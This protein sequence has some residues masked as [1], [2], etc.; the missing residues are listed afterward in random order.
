MKWS[1]LALLATSCIASHV[2]LD[3]KSSCIGIQYDFGD[4]GGA[5]DTRADAVKAAYVDAWNDYADHAFGFD[6]YNPLTKTGTTG[7]GGWGLI[8]IDGFDTAVIMGLKDI[9]D[10]QL[11]H[12]ASQ[13]F[14]VSTDP[15]I[16]EFD[17]IIRLIGGLL[18][19]YDLIT[20]QLVPFAGDYNQTQVAKLLD[21]AKTLADF[22][23]P[24]FSSPTG[25]PYFWINT[26]TR[27]PSEGFF[28][29]TAT[30]G[31]VIL[32][33]HRLSDLTGDETY[34]NQADRAEAWLLNPQPAPV[35]P[36][37]VG[38]QVNIDSGQFENENAGW[39]SGVDSFFE[40]LIKSVVYDDTQQYAGEYQSFWTTAVES[41]QQH[42]AVHP[43]NHSELTFINILNNTGYPTDE[44]D[45][46]S[47]FAGGNW[48]LGEHTC[49]ALYNSTASGLNPLA[50]GWYDAETNLAYEAKYNNDS[51]EAAVARANADEWGYFIRYDDYGA[52]YT[53]YPE[54]IESMF[55]AWRI[56]GDEK[57]RDY[58]WEVF[59][60]Q[61]RDGKR[62]PVTMSSL[63]NVSMPNGGDQYPDIPSY[64]F[65]ET[66]KYLYLTFA[67]TDLVRLDAF[68]FN[69]EAHPMR[70]QKGT[71]AAAESS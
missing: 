7:S 13:N 15:Q 27:V 67:D 14:N 44:M 2:N 66:L 50:I 24:V 65:A 59:Q 5:N 37:L 64:Y 12:I 21:G 31:T 11:Q 1:I 53:L 25:L 8:I 60:A 61:Q 28:Q 68:V 40:Y 26:T 6:G 16:D 20:S 45:D 46:Y 17:T 30:F 32:E 35:Y 57:W 63:F 23:S 56:T 54:P 22:L 29:N 3:K 55:Y 39:Q 48:L 9:A 47:C 71:C 62:P 58:N 52:L 38:S 33:Y 69:T 42:L 34:R 19:S 51:S 4:N 36:S 43:Y 70:V 18:S 49:H 41:T 10:R